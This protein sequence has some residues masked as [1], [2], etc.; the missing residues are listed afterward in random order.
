MAQELTSS[1][2][3]DEKKVSQLTGIALSTLRQDRFHRR[4]LPFYKFGGRVLYKLDEVLAY[5]NNCRIEV[6]AV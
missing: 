6:D 5:L 2:F 1:K 3:V 4:R